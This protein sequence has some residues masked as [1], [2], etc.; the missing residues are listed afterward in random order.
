MNKRKQ[1]VFSS[2]CW[3][4]YLFDDDLTRSELSETKLCE[5]MRDT[6]RSPLSHSFLPNIARRMAQEIFPANNI[7]PELRKWSSH[8]NNLALRVS[9]VGRAFGARDNTDQTRK[10]QIFHRVFRRGL[11][12]GGPPR[13]P[14]R[15]IALVNMQRRLLF[16]S[17]AKG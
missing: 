6:T 7:F 2:F 10:R 9:T 17:A 8:I 4:L 13:L 11:R 14:P 1:N 5:N 16:F 3:S 12:T 15:I